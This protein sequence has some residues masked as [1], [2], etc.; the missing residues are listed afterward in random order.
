MRSW[1]FGV[2]F[3]SGDWIDR[4]LS[5]RRR[6]A[7]HPVI[8]WSTDSTRE[9]LD[10]LLHA[11]HFARAGYASCAIETVSH[12]SA[13]HY[14]EQLLS[15]L[16]F[17][18]SIQWKDTPGQARSLSYLTPTPHPSSLRAGEDSRLLRPLHQTP[19]SSSSLAKLGDDPNLPG[20]GDPRH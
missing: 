6:R 16:I 19:G 14:D 12:S 1:P 13:S 18:L 20:E 8:I 10:L 3:Q 4:D 9:R 11:G 5:A 15:E 17:K 7:P 2:S